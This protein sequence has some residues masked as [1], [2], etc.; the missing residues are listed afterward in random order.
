VAEVTQ[1]NPV[2]RPNEGS[3]AAGEVP[4]WLSADELEEVARRRLEPA[5]YD[6]IAG[7]AGEELTLAANRRAF[8]LLALRPRIL[9]GV[10][11]VSTQAT[12]FG[13]SLA[14]PLFVSPMGGPAHALVQPEGVFGTASGAAQAGVAYMVSGSSAPTLDLPG[15]ARICQVYLIDRDATIRLLGEAEQLGYGAICLT[16]DVP[17]SAL[18]RRN[19]RHGKGVPADT[20][21]PVR[22]GF[23]NPD[24]YAHPTSW[25]DVE[26]MRSIAKL[27]LIVKGVMTGEDA[28]IAVELGIDGV[29]VSNHGGR[30]IDHALGTVEVLPEVVDAVGG[31]AAVMIDGGVRTSTDVAIALALGA[32]AVGMGKAVMWAYA[33]AGAPG[34]ANFLQSI[35]TDLTRTMALL[36]V[37]TIADLGP[38]FVDQRHAVQRRTQP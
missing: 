23:S 32:Q 8:E 20:A 18:R 30:Q 37:A 24:F 33:A 2:N 3:T 34:V 19:L 9:T 10:Q 12:L 25:R 16:A 6:Y 29:V 27:P 7:G 17:V 15:L 4:P 26:W 31:R 13:M 35:I 38:G 28:H 21:E 11:K 22:G 5:A 1:R 36:G 14:A